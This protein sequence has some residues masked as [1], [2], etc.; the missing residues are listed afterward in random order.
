MTALT[1]VWDKAKEFLF[2][3]RTAYIRT[4]DFS[5]PPAN[6]V[7][8]DL[9]KFCRANVS[10]ADQDPIISARLDGRREVWLRIQHHLRL[11]PEQ[12]WEL[13]SGIKD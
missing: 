6:E 13:Y 3:R 1:D 8:I 5:S 2:R 10:T 11:K 12:L 7:L 9:A 4:F